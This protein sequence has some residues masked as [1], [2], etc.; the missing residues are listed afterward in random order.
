MKSIFWHAGATLLI[1]ALVL[2][3]AAPKPVHAAGTVRY[4]SPNGKTTGNCDGSW[5]NACTLQR[6]LTVAV[7]GDEIWV[8]QGV[9]YP[10]AARSDS[11]TLS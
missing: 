6:A 1:V 10:G 8:R 11:F 3:L 5:A 4:A 7:S 2:I 9:Y